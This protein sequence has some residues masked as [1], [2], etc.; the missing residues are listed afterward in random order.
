MRN[1]SELLQ[2]LDMIANE[3]CRRPEMYAF[4]AEC[5]E[6]E[7]LTLMSLRDFILD[8][9]MSRDRKRYEDF[10]VLHDFGAG[11]F[12]HAGGPCEKLTA[13]EQQSF[14]KLA[15]FIAEYLSWRDVG[16]AEK[17]TGTNGISVSI[18]PEKGPEKVSGT[19]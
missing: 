5:L 3:M 2:R 19:D 15:D 1:A 14:K 17:G 10:L 7:F 12:S 11:L 6:A 18:W 8:D 9:Q 13:A 16:P 4:S